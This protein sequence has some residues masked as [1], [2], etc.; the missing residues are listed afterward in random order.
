M[1]I[2]G[3]NGSGFNPYGIGSRPTVTTPA[4]TPVPARPAQTS[5]TSS[6]SSEPATAQHSVADAIKSDAAARA[7]A[8]N[9]AQA[10]DG[11]DQDLWSV[12]TKEERSFFV[13][14]GAMG[15]LTYGRFSNAQGPTQAPLVRGGRLDI[16]A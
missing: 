16:K 4:N 5:S 14:A 8:V 10:P 3:I 15:P 13:K 9:S 6:T 1:A 2:N 12:L 11:V 7:A